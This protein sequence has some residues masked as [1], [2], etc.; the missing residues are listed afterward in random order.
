MS[1]DFV[2]HAVPLQHFE[3]VQI[4]DL[5]ANRK[6]VPHELIDRLLEERRRLIQTVDHLQAVLL[7]NQPKPCPK[8][9]SA[10][11][12]LCFDLALLQKEQENLVEAA[13]GHPRRSRGKKSSRA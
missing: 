8:C 11:H 10:H 1:R 6:P 5:N 2:P 4:M 3:V 12:V 7:S 9:G 13:A